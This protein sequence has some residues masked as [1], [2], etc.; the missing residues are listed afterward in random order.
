ML[1]VFLLS[2]TINEGKS[3]Y[4][5]GSILVLSYLVVTVGFYLAGFTD[6]EYRKVETGSTGS[7][8]STMAVGSRGSRGFAMRH[9][10]L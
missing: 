10:G 4:F 9:D 1:T 7:Q 3:N 6:H 2:Y 5:K 8:F